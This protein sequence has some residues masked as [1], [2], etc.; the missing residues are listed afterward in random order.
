VCSGIFINKQFE[1]SSGGKNAGNS[2]GLREAG[3]VSTLTDSEFHLAADDCITT[4]RVPG[5]CSKGISSASACGS[6]I[7]DAVDVNIIRWRV[8][9]KAQGKSRRRINCCSDK[10][11]ESRDDGCGMFI[12]KQF[13][14]GFDEGGSVHLVA[15]GCFATSIVPGPCSKGISSSSARGGCIFDAIDVNIIRWR[16]II[17]IIIIIYIYSAHIPFG[18]C[19]YAHDNLIRR[20]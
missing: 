1:A 20:I 3:S 17:I 6:S 4:I 2:G 13:D 9:V 7:F 11:A 15:N 8:V 18:I 10:N 5:P 19:S 16:V 12:N 14:N